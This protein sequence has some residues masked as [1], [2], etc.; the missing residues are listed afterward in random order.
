MVLKVFNTLTRKKETFKPIETKK[1]TL[2]VCGPTVYDFSH[3]GH[4]RTYLAFDIIANYLRFRGYDV[5]YLMNITDI[6]DKIIKKAKEEKIDP[7][8]LAKHFEKEFYDDL[9][10][11]GIFNNI[12]YFAKAS[13]H[14]PEIIN[15]IEI[16]IEKKYAYRVDNDIY[17]DIEK[18]PDYGKLSN[19][20]LDEL[21]T[22]RIKPDK[23]KK[24]T[25][26]FSL[27]KNKTNEKVWP[28]PWGDGRPGWHIEDTA[29]TLKH[30]GTNYCI[31]GGAIELAFPHHE[32]EIAQAESVTGIKPLAK[33]WMH[34]GLLMIKEQKMSK[35][36]K[37]YVSIKDILDK[38]DS[39]TLKLFFASSH[40][41]SPIDFKPKE[42]HEF[43]F[44][45]YKDN[46]QF[47]TR[48]EPLKIHTAFIN[49]KWIKNFMNNM[50]RTAMK[51]GKKSS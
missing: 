16:L 4:L 20:K 23:R 50:I 9:K 36:L 15:Q 37:N 25:Q 13:E 46:Y 43:V 6:D 48:I 32:A 14:I 2:F 19:Q 39:S 27:W 44:K 17:F 49:N 7:L 12:N 51:G 38:Y 29:I 21:K 5:F 26:D 18:F 24:N 34:T 40:Y 28:S 10:Q 35:S 45:T 22:I 30:L 8:K 11:I 33:Y 3:L 41:R 42:C 1:V 31:H 47:G